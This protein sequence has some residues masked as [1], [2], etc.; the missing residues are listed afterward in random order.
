MPPPDSYHIKGSF[1]NIEETQSGVQ[2]TNRY[3]SFGRGRAELS[4]LHIDRVAMLAKKNLLAPG[5]GTYPVP[6]SFGVD[7]MQKSFGV[8]L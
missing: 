7:G 1:G 4:P 2:D 3:Y 6:R 5:P 8:R